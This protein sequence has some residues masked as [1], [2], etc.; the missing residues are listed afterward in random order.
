M[1]WEAYPH[2]RRGRDCG[3]NGSEGGGPKLVCDNH[4]MPVF[5]LTVM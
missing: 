3:K 2:I 5:Y 4:A 1:R